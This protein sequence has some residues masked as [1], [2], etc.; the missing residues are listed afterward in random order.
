[1]SQD[2]FP[3]PIKIRI[4][5]LPP[6]KN[7]TSVKYLISQFIPFKQILN[8]K[9]LPLIPSM[10]PPFIPLQSC[11]VILRHY[12]DWP[13]LLLQINGYQWEY[14][15]LGAI[16]L[17]SLMPI[18]SRDSTSNNSISNG[19][20]M[21]QIFNEQSFRK[22]MSSRNMWQLKVS[23]FPPCLHWD[24][25]IK[26][27]DLEPQPHVVLKG[28][29]FNLKLIIKT[30]HPEKFGKLKWTILKDFIKLKC[31]ELLKIDRL[32]PKNTKEFYVGVYEDDEIDVKIILNPN[33]HD[34]DQIEEVN[35]DIIKGLNNLNIEDLPTFNVRATKFK[36]I[37]GFH[38]KKLYD[39]CFNTLNGQ[40]YML[41]YELNVEKLSNENENG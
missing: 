5:N 23:N 1:M 15:T 39:A 31:P 8:V 25:V 21:R 3:V 19:R 40:E 9:L 7:W 6:G 13:Y 17:P 2:I 22:Q 18:L 10:A 29:T 16:I 34:K 33:E 12:S 38:S 24:E 32:N 26:S 27:N 11:I 30:S 14:H 37:I 35:D 28:E 4:D 36:V 41:G 20:K